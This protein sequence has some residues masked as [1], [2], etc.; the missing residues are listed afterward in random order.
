MYRKWL[1]EGLRVEGYSDLY[2]SMIGNATR[3]S[4]RKAEITGTRAPDRIK[5]AEHMG[6]IN[7]LTNLATLYLHDSHDLS[8]KDAGKLIRDHI[9]QWNKATDEDEERD[10]QD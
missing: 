4:R 10:K 5:R 3:A 7:A 8:E 1:R 9:A 2:I 6:E